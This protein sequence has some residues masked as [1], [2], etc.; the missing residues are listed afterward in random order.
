MLNITVNLVLRNVPFNQASFS[1]SFLTSEYFAFRVTYQLL[2]ISSHFFC[3]SKEMGRYDVTITQFSRKQV[4]KLGEACNS[5]IPAV[6]FHI[7]NYESLCITG[8][9]LIVYKTNRSV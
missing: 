2:M 3:L 7:D 8:I 5:F 4:V 1:A 6:G 9:Y